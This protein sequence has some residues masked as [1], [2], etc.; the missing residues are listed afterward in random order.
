MSN[1]AFVLMPG[2]RWFELFYPGNSLESIFEFQ[3]NDKYAQ[4]NSLYGM[5]NRN[6]H[7]YIPSQRANESFARK[8]ALELTRGENASST[9]LSEDNYLIWKYVGMAPDGKTER[10]GTVQN[11]CDYI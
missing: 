8:Y 6:A 7:Q 2:S 5:T 3:F 11:S 1:K 9:K 4:K 10:F